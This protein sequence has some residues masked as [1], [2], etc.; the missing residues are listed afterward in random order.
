[1]LMEPCNIKPVDFF[2][3]IY[4]LPYS[5]LLDSCGLGRYS[6]A[7]TN[8]FAL[9]KAHDDKIEIIGD[10]AVK[11][12]TGNIFSVLSSLL[13][14]F[15]ITSKS[16]YFPF[17]GGAVGY[18]GY[19]L[20]N[21]VENLPRK[22]LTEPV[23][24]DCILGFYDTIFAYDHKTGKGYILSSGL[25]E[26]EG[27]KRR[28]RAKERI[29]QFIKNIGA[30]GN[31]NLTPSPLPSP[32]G[33]DGWLKG[34][35]VVNSTSN[36]TKEGY[37]DAIKRIQD[38]IAAGDIYQANLSQRLNMDFTGT[39]LGLYEIIRKINPVPF[40]AF[41]NYGDFQIMSN[42]PERLLKIH[43]G[44]AETSPIKG[45]RPR[46]RG[47]KEDRNLIKE[48]K[49]NAKELSEHIMIVDLE[50]NDLGRFCDPGS[51]KV[52][53]LQKIYTY[54]TLHHMVSTVKGKVR[55]GM[56]TADC[57]KAF[58]PGGSVTGAP[59]IRAMEIIDELEPTPRG[60][61]TGAI[62]YIDFSGN[63][64]LSMTIRT[65]I[66]KDK[67]LYLHVGGGIVADSNPAEE[68]DETLLK[69]Q[70][71]LKAMGVSKKQADAE[72]KVNNIK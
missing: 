54:P 43:N 61:Y 9:L 19:D 58:F 72:V 20:K 42:S 6:F 45:T 41:L 15:K 51:I 69:A 70:A 16:H 31:E 29:G 21:Q 67:K 59:K 64:D 53:P 7:G 8:P 4:H 62:G 18:L 25:P 36:F 24:P 10:S 11:V 27:I 26:K 44:I 35:F 47:H 33:G 37:I 5:F 49:T 17:Q 71:F 13:N 55:D 50:R 1:M 66:L 12:T 22:G 23:V 57:I 68:Y 28:V 38:Y 39:P 32:L 30:K 52:N 48:L 65:A 46:G 63:M 3:R 40:G 14:E 2:R 60:I 56:E 34:I